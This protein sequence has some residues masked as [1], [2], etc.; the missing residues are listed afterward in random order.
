[1]R[2]WMILCGVALLFNGVTESVEIGI[3]QGY[4][5]RW[6]GFETAIT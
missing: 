4:Q 6:T 5:I 1:M 2:C 3:V